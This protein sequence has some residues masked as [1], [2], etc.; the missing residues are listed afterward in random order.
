MFAYGVFDPLINLG[1][2]VVACLLVM[3]LAPNRTPALLRCKSGVRKLAR[4]PW[5]CAAILFGLSFGLNGLL[6]AIH[7]PLPWIHDEFSYLLAS[8]TFANGRLT[9]PVSTLR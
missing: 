4:H 3:I 5:W 6:A 2:A 8:D 7:P 9:N 1:V